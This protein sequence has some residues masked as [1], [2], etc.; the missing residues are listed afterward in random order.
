MITNQYINKPIL[1]VGKPGTG[2]TTKA[3]ELLGDDYIVRYADEY[4][5]EDNFSIPPTTGILIEEVNYKPNVDLIVDTLL[6]FRGK[7]ILTSL[8]QKDVPKRIFNLCKLKRAGTTNYLLR[9]NGERAA[10]ADSPVDYDINI[11]EM[12]HDYLKNYD[13]DSVLTKLKLNKPY[14]EQFLSWLV[15]NMHP[16]KIAYI[17]S[18]VKRKWS[19]DYFYELLAYA[20][21]GKISRK[22]VVPSRRAYS[23]MPSICRR[24]G[25][26]SNE[27]YLLEQ[28]LEDEDFAEYVKRKVNHTERRMLNL[29]EKKRKIRKKQ[30]KLKGLEE[31]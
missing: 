24:V 9:L 2:K 22:V 23:K 17:D 12:L 25:L 3:L 7:V 19:Q 21:N 29:G 11:F 18:K 30:P 13:R 10:N 5:I 31:W 4:D 16:N 14:D 8:N 1:I 28:L 26:K 27:S 20:H 6:Q 15:M